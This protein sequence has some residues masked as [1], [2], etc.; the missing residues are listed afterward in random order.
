[1]VLCR[2]RIARGQVILAT[3]QSIKNTFKEILQPL[4]EEIEENVETPKSLL[5]IL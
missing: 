3:V 2:N 5:F 1:M 4:D